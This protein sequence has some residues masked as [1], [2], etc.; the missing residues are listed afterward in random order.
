MTKWLSIPT[1]NKES[2]III[3]KHITLITKHPPKSHLFCFFMYFCRNTYNMKTA[4]L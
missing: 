4:K 3:K 2:E 1:T